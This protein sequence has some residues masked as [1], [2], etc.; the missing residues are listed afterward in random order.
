MNAAGRR[1][2]ELTE[3]EDWS[4]AEQKIALAHRGAGRLDD[5]LRHIDLARSSSTTPSPLQQVRLDTAHGHIL[6]TDP[7]THNEGIS[8]LDRAAATRS[9]FAAD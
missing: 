2:D 4:V 5:A 9:D 8:I 6:L 7:A 1:F 3:P